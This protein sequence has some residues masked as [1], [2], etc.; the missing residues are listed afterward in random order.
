IEE[1]AVWFQRNESERSAENT[2]H[3]PGEASG[4]IKEH[5]IHSILPT[6]DNFEQVHSKLAAHQ[7]PDL[8]HETASIHVSKLIKAHGSIIARRS[9]LLQQPCR[10]HANGRDACS[11]HPGVVKGACRQCA[12]G[13]SRV[14]PAVLPIRRRPHEEGSNLPA[15]V[16]KVQPLY[17]QL[18]IP[19]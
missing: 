6:H 7:L 19:E 1:F 15:D 2:Q 13:S 18:L 3:L 12:H 9:V 8:G 5:Q 4:V 16:N 14:F 10:V 17:E 11:T